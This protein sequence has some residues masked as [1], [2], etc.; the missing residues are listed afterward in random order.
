MDIA[1]L[2]DKLGDETF[3][4]LQGYVTDLVGQRDAAR[5]ES[6]EGRKKLKSERDQAVATAAKALEKLGVDSAD[7]LDSL[8]DAKGQAE[9]LKQYESRLKRSNQ[10]RDEFKKAFEEEQLSR[11]EDK[12]Q[13][14]LATAMQGHEFVAPD[15]VLAYAD[16]RMVWEGEDW[17]FKTDDGKLLSPKDGFATIAKSRPELLKAAGTGGAG[18]RQANAG[19]GGKSMTEAE[20]NAKSPREQAQLMASG[21]TLTD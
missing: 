15:V 14:A 10:E 16:R 7:E 6:I 9:A 19:S 20:F 1:K 18:V 5:T 13:I 4:E 2:K 17:Q 11:R 3:A 8:P 21:Y 12:K